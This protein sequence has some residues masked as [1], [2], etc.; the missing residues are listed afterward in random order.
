M[1]RTHRTLS[2]AGKVNSLYVFDALARAARSQINKHRLVPPS[3]PSQG[4]CATF[5]V[6]VEGVLDS[7]WQ[8]L[9]STRDETL[10]V[11][12]ASLTDV[13]A[14]ALATKSIILRSLLVCTDLVPAFSRLY[15][16][17][18]M[19][20][21]TQAS[22]AVFQDRAPCPSALVSDLTRSTLMSKSRRAH[23]AS[24]C[25]H[26][27]S[28]LSSH[29]RSF[30]PASVTLGLVRRRRQILTWSTI[31]SAYR[32]NRRKSLIFG[33]RT[34]HSRQPPSNGCRSY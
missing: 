3:D 12:L 15:V 20:N 2:P 16:P 9:L 34:T 29:D 8:D 19:G 11:S 26:L 33:S 13:T 21:D 25:M 7:L 17:G 1:F 30:T 32:R 28:L 6:K 22:L 27:A 10:K 4:N 23:V 5:I 24:A 14:G 31:F 18:D